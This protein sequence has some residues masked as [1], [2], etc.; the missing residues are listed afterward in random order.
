MFYS[1]TG[2]LLF[3]KN[4]EQCIKFYK[5]TLELPVIFEEPGVLTT[6]KFGGGYLMVEDFGTLAKKKK[7]FSQNPTILRFDTTFEAFTQSTEFLEKKGINLELTTYDW[8]HTATFH[9]PDGNTCEL[10]APQAGMPSNLT[11]R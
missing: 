8:G 3:T 10:Y 6:F 11:E 1:G 2:I 7:N 5:K 9:D 4:F